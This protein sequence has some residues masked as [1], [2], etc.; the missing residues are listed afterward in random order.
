M[1]KKTARLMVRFSEEERT[2][3]DAMAEDLGLATAAFVRSLVIQHMKE[4][5]KNDA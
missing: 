1:A 3:L 5:E 4:K 2:A